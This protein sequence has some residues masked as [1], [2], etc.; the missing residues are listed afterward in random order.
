MTS[1][2]LKILKNKMNNLLLICKFDKLMKKNSLRVLINSKKRIS[3]YR[4][5]MS[6]YSKKL[7]SIANKK[8]YNMK[9]NK[10]KINRNC[11][12]NLKV[13]KHNC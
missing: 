1:H 4:I 3:N 11:F 8:L 2:T 9:F 12:L 7:K 5:E 10:T 6:N 13:N